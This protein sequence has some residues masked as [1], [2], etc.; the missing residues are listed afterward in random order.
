MEGTKE[1]TIQRKT[2]IDVPFA[3]EVS[4]VRS[5]QH[6]YKVQVGEISDGC[7]LCVRENT[8]RVLRLFKN[9]FKSKKLLKNHT[10]QRV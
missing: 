1:F 3:E 9:E 2:A 8:D 7:P 4:N 5:C 6:D 10:H